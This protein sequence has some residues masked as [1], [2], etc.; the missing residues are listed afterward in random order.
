MSR[1]LLLALALAAA[2]T[3]SAAPPP[4]V[5]APVA[6]PLVE[7]DLVDRSLRRAE[8]RAAQRELER[9]RDVLQV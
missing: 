9:D 3:A 4:S 1:P 6:S 8:A 2:T 7:L 5:R